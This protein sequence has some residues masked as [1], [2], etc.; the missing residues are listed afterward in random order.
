M[1]QTNPSANKVMLIRHAEKPMNSDAPPYGINPKGLRDNESLTVRGWQRAG[2]L[3][4]LFD[5]LTGVFQSPH[6]S[7]PQFVYASKAI[8]GSSSDSERPQQTVTPLLQ[9]LKRTNVHVNF[10]FCKGDEQALA[11][12]ALACNGVVLIC[13]EHKNIHKIVHHLLKN[14]KKK[15]AAPKTWPDKR[16]D[17]VWVFDWDPVTEGYVFHRVN[18]QLLDGD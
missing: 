10:D 4:G 7:T 6:L 5:P 17:M 11:I 1:A 16:F 14:Q 2:A 13:W 12:S 8:P 3:V 9:K 18:Q 15:I